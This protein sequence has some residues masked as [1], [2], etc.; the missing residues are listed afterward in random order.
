MLGRRGQAGVW[1]GLSKGT[2]M[3]MTA[4]AAPGGDVPPD[5][6][7]VTVSGTSIQATLNGKSSKTDELVEPLPG[8][9]G[10][11]V[12]L[13]FEVGRIPEETSQSRWATL[14]ATLPFLPFAA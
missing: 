5:L 10:E 13:G 2:H 12:P 7:K 8:F 9:A 14:V 6:D 4:S 1:P 11:T 3:T